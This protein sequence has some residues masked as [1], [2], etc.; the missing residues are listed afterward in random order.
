MILINISPRTARD[1]KKTKRT[2]SM[3][4]I[5]LLVCF[6]CLLGLSAAA[7]SLIVHVR[8][9]SRLENSEQEVLSVQKNN[10]ALADQNI[11][12]RNSLQKLED[13]YSK[14]EPRYKD[15]ESRLDAAKQKNMQ[16]ASKLATASKDLESAKAGVLRL[17]DE[18][19]AKLS[20]IVALNA[21]RQTL[22]QKYDDLKE[23]LAPHL[24]LEPTWVRPGEATQ[25][26]DGNLLI[27]LYQASEKDKC[28]KD[29]MAVSYLI[30][31]KDKKKLC[32]ETGKPENFTYQGKRYVFNLLQSKESGG[33]HRYCIYI[34]K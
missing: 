21:N 18:L 4:P 12:L 19:D 23:M 29:S 5:T 33:T 27:I 26:F 16:M 15:L 22:E 2:V 6:V 34:I 28:H 11:E 14:L 8:Y 1:G 13:E 31:G 24:V 9:R 25:A 17:T 20:E 3:R 32:L 7:I 30:S 10:K